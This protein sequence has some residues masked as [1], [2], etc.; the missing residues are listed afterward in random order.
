VNGAVVVR[1]MTTR[2]EMRQFHCFPYRI[3][4]DDS[5][6]VP[7]LLPER[8]SVTNPKKGM[9]FQRGDAAFFA[10]YR[11]G[12]MVGTICAA[13]DRY[14]IK[15]IGRREC[16][17][18]F[19]EVINDLEVA[20]ALFDRA[21]R[22]GFD[23]RLDSLV[24][25]FNL[26]YEDGYGI[27]TDG[28]DRPP[29][30]LCGHTPEYYVDLVQQLGFQPARPGNIALA[31][32]LVDPP[33]QLD[34][35]TRAAD[36]ARKRGGFRI[37]PADIKNWRDE[38][39][40]VHY[41]LN[42]SLEHSGEAPVPWPREAVDSLVKPFLRIAD[43][44]LVLFADRTT[45]RDAGKTVG[46]FAGIPNMNEVLVHGKGLRY[47]WNYPPLLLSLRQTPKCL[48]VKSLL[49]LPE[50]H[51]SGVAPLLFDEMSRRAQEKGYSWIDLSLTSEAN[52]E[53]PILAERSGAVRYKRYQIYRRPVTRR[54]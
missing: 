3:Y 22:W 42:N 47:P 10:A 13:E 16:V 43:P 39:S 50:Y 21:E 52:P 26:D 46:W 1:E 31:I 38:A 34:R 25:P 8:M 35:L 48:A 49:V 44:E 41:L 14:E 45:G 40:R 4:R 37:R 53:T 19:F 23:H 54:A 12:E 17:F 32:D 24:G 18:G 11:D 36:I 7:P 28:R 5:L 6:W 29:V 9:F 20:H 51:S 30:I 2:R 27:L 15:H 33:S